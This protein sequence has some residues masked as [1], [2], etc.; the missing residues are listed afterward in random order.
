M[1]EI[2]ANG[3]GKVKFNRSGAQDDLLAV[4]SVDG[5][6]VKVFSVQS[7]FVNGVDKFACVYSYDFTRSVSSSTQVPVS[8][9]L[10]CF[11][12]D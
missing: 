7:N 1:A 2:A 12:Y 5:T 3:V 8:L 10:S 4:A 6:S 11:L 9:L